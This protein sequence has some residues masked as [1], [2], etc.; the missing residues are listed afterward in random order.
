MRVLYLVLLLAVISLT[1]KA[2]TYTDQQQQNRSYQVQH[3]A[4]V[5]AYSVAPSSYTPPVYKSRASSGSTSASSGSAVE[6]STTVRQSSSTQSAYVRSDIQSWGS[7]EEEYT[8]KT[9]YRPSATAPVLPYYS[10]SK[11]KNC[12]GDCQ[13]T[14]KT[15]D[16]DIVYTGNTRYGYP[17]GQGT[18]KWSN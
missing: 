9:S 5:R 8:V 4:T 2:Q 3:A 7:D 1:G 10:G 14:L 16:K 11:T 15:R 17:H 12:Q 18:F 13:E 6:N